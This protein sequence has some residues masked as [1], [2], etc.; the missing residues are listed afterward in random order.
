MQTNI[1]SL[2]SPTPPGASEIKAMMAAAREGGMAIA[3]RFEEDARILAERAR[4]LIELKD[5]V[6]VGVLEEARKIAAEMDAAADRIRRVL[7]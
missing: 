2:P 5:A 3:R 4:E 1:V 6:P 7:G